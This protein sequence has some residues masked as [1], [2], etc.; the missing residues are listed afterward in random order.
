MND[1]LSDDESTDPSL[2]HVNSGLNDARDLR[3][4]NVKAEME[5]VADEFATENLAMSPNDIY[6]EISRKMARKYGKLYHGHN[7]EYISALV[8]RV[9]AKLNFGDTFRAA[10]GIYA[11]MANGEGFFLHPTSKFGSTLSPLCSLSRHFYRHDLRV[12]PDTLLSDTNYY[13]SQPNPKHVCSGDIR[14]DDSQNT[15]VVLVSKCVCTIYV[16]LFGR[17]ENILSLLLH[18]SRFI[19]TQMKLVCPGTKIN[20]RNFACDWK[21]AISKQFKV[22]FPEERLIVSFH[23]KQAL[24]RKVL[25]QCGFNPDDIALSVQKGY[26][27][28]LCVI[29]HAEVVKD[30]IPCV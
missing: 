7:R 28:L 13:D 24:R 21:T 27:D 10:K 4:V 12:H 14:S 22:C 6:L 2:E 9:R 16:F 30:G 11:R 1:D 18:I 29:P 8:H 19:F 23:F 3:P 25:N 15:G 26:I 20:C 5:M 17:H